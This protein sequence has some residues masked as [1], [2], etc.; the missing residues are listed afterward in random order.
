M[1]MIM[2]LQPA[3][4]ILTMQADYPECSTLDPAS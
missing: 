2:R 4:G 1:L 3:T